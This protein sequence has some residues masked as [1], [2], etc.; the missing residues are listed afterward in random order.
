[1]DAA[2]RHASRASV[3]RRDVRKRAHL[4]PERPRRSEAGAAR[5]SGCGDRRPDP[6]RLGRAPGAAGDEGR[7]DRPQRRALMARA[8]TR[9]VSPRLS[10]CALT[11]L[12]RTPIDVA[13]AT[14]QH[15]A[16]EQALANAGFQLIRLPDLP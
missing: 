10:E 11:H 2:R 12:E 1:S 16:Y 6:R 9:A 13:R 3:D 5:R 4:A 7:T 15:A 14:A 8:F